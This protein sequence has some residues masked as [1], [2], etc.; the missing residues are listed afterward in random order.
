VRPGTPIAVNPIAIGPT[1][2]PP[3]KPQVDSGK[4]KDPRNPEKPPKEHEKPKEPASDGSTGLR[5]VLSGV[6]PFIYA[7]WSVQM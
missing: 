3:E 6:S 7:R 2:K 5:L 1:F 4:N